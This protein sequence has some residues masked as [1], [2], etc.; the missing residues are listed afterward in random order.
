MSGFPPAFAWDEQ[1][2]ADEAEV[3]DSFFPVNLRTRGIVFDAYVSNPAI[4][5]LPLEEIMQPTLVV[6]ALDDPLASYADALAMAQRIRHARFRT[7]RSGGH[8]FMHRD[9]DV[10]AEVREFLLG[11]GTAPGN[12][13]ALVP[14]GRRHRGA[15]I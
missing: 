9:Q 10:V 15:T 14:A 8:V 3:I 6:H 13:S 4:A 1:A 12:E 11:H 5:G 2:H 7:V